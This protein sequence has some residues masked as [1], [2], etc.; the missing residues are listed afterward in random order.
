MSL[1]IHHLNCGTMCPASARLV[2]G[3]GGLFERAQLVCHCLLIESND[4]LVLVDTGLGTADVAD[5]TRLGRSFLR[6]SA[7][8]LDVNETALAHVERLGFR[9]RDV[10][11]IVPTHLDLDH[12]GGLADFPE[13]E[14]HVFDEEYRA[15][16]EPV[17][18][19][20]QFGYR[21]VQWAHG[22]R[23]AS[24]PLA[25]EQWF[26]FEAVRAIPALGEQVLLVPLRG[27]SAGHCGVAVRTHEGWLLHA[28]DAYFSHLELDLQAPRTPLGLSLFQ[29]LRS[30]DDRARLT[31]QARL[32][33]LLRQHGSEV[34]VFSAHCAVEL[35]RAQAQAP[36]V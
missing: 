24:V 32:R 27:H 10:R 18:S 23:W 36:S 19:S 25:G 28:G 5:P 22:P 8:R 31:N 12:V 21:Q 7:P 11:H 2:T 34:R 26:G 6:R 16:M 4:G 29:R 3:R 15:G 33:S 17:G 30:V 20:A 13:A 1:R 35:K 14:V 9:A